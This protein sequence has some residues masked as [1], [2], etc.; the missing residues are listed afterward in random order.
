MTMMTATPASGSRRSVDAVALLCVAITV[1]T[2]AS[3]FAAIRV[4]LRA[5]SPVEL[6]AARYIGGAVPAGLYL[7]LTRQ[8]VPGI[9]T[10]MRL[11]LIG[12]LFVAG[13]ATLLNTGE[14]TVPA[15]PASFIINT[16]PVF[17]ALMAGLLLGERFG[18]RA[19]FGT[20]ISLAGVGV[21]AVSGGSGFRLDIGA[22]LI[23]GAAICSAVSSILQKPLLGRMPPLVVTAWVLVLGAA[24]LLAAAPS[25]AHALFRAPAETAWS[26]L[27]LA[28]APT[29]VGYA[30]WAMALKRLPASRAANFLYCVPPAATLIGFAWLGETP[31][32][33]GLIGGAMA[34]AGVAVVNLMRKA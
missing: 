7:I 10:L 33:L 8:P 9:R 1:L 15:G 28:L 6:A 3:A 23:L 2:W 32:A 4:G 30:T 19:W 24:P 18:V 16:M 31:S 11:A 20:A 21:I 14:T 34:I 12:L 29:A 25:A 27:Y 13:Y 22:V 26:V 5:L 17:V